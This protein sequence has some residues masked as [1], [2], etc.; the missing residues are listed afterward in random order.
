MSFKSIKV[1]AEGELCCIHLRPGTRVLLIHPSRSLENFGDHQ[2]RLQCLSDICPS[3]AHPGP[4]TTSLGRPASGKCGDSGMEGDWEKRC[5]CVPIIPGGNNH[6][7]PEWL[8]VWKAPSWSEALIYLVV[9]KSD[10]ASS[11]LE[12]V[13]TIL[14][15]RTT[16]DQLS[17]TL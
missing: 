4:L 10:S 17:W 14:I 7:G 13:T 12:G 8:Q 15:L 16:S 2:I 3:R 1:T 11:F 6:L 9:F 5:Q